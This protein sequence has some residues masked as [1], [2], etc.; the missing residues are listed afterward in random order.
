MT[1]DRNITIRKFTAIAT[2][3]AA[4]SMAGSLAAA[5]APSLR[6]SYCKPELVVIMMVS[7]DR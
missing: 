3:M 1:A 7:P 6:S 5:P 4:L 2:A